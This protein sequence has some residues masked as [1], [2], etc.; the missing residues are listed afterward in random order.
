M[1]K[2]HN[3]K[4]AMIPPN[5]LQVRMNEIFEQTTRSALKELSGAPWVLLFN[6]DAIE[7]HHHHNSSE[8][9]SP[10]PNVHTAIA[11]DLLRPLA[12][13]AKKSGGDVIMIKG[14][15]CHV[16]EFESQIGEALGAIPN[17]ATGEFA[18]DEL[19]VV[20]NGIMC[21]FK[22]HM[23]VTSRAHL[24]A[25]AMG[26][27]MANQ[28]TNDAR[29][30]KRIARFMG[31]AHRHVGGIFSTWLQTFMVTPSYQAKTP[32]GFKVVPESGQNFGCG[33]ALAKE[34]GQ[35]FDVKLH[36]ESL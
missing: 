20:I 15:P 28:T 32:H 10:N 9:I 25:S 35:M 13:A 27:V 11:I 22:H 6:G 26:I 33:T 19:R 23:P 16:G 3:H 17:E 1:P 7:G 12:D 14:T 30:G 4:G 36:M 29:D 24:E 34:R 31:R 21:D 18:F 8:I 5:P 2:P